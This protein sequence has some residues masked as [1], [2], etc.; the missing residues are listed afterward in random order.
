MKVGDLVIR[1]NDLVCR[2]LGHGLII[3]MHENPDNTWFYQVKWIFEIESL[4]Y[5]ETELEVLS[6]SR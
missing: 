5:N 2:N 3:N 4:W 6:E 1:N